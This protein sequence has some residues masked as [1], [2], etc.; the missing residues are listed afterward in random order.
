MI[1]P[2]FLTLAR[3]EFSRHAHNDLAKDGP[4]IEQQMLT[5]LREAVASKPI[6]I[7]RVSINHIEFD[8]TVTAAISAK[9][10]SAQRLEQKEFE[11]KIAERD[12]EIARTAARGRADVIRTEA[13]GEAEAT[14]V[15]GQAQA[16]AQA[17]ITKTLTANYLRYKAFDNDATRY[18]FVPVG[19]DGMPILVSTDSAA[20]Q[21][22]QSPPRSRNV[23]RR[24]PAL[25]EMP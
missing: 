4:A 2:P 18:Y 6:E 21:P 13:Q 14:V 19:R 8:R 11:L 9:L 1:R 3:S 10:A 12:G 20:A 23:G 17:D 16:H 25:P 7:D 15:K 22:S 5:K 24:F